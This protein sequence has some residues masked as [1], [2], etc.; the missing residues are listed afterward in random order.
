MVSHRL[1]VALSTAAAVILSAPFIQQAF[2][3]A[4]S[5]WGAHFRAVGMAVS[6]LPVSIALLV[7]A[8]RI[9]DRRFARYLKLVASLAIAAAYILI[10][11]LSFAEAFHFVEYG[12][13][14]WL[15]YGAM[16]T[17]DDGSLIVL[18]LLAGVLVGTLD[19]WFQWFI[20]IRAGEA[21]DILL[22]GVA[23]GCGLLFAMA[24]DPPTGSV[25]TLRRQSVARVR[26][27][28]GAAVAVF[29]LFFLT[30]HAGRDV[31]GAEIGAFRSRYTG[32]QLEA[33][34]RDRAERWWSRPPLVLRRLSREDQY[35]TEGLWH[36]QRRNQ[37]L[38]AGDVAEAWRENRILERFYA[39]LLE[40]PTYA[41]PSGHRWS[42]E[43]RLEA[44]RWPSVDRAPSVSDAYP[45][46]LYVW[47][48][49]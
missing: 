13:L 31:H 5:T 34:A 19:E 26:L 36:V 2:T 39:P 1:A 4:S 40:T 30:A 22:N 15:F 7:A 43:Q 28:R 25:A 10:E 18:P 17:R 27:W 12:L 32:E 46:P 37:A 47:P 48:G 45:Y 41:D 29:G 14:A 49:E 8:R 24:I 20:P 44:E 38:S 42:A 21:R 16:R 35:L 9:R 33:L 3:A 11:A 6:V 23:S